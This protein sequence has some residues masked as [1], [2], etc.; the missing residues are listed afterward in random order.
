MKIENLVVFVT[1]FTININ[2]NNNKLLLYT[3]QTNFYK[4]LR[5]NNSKKIHS[6]TIEPAGYLI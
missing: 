4:L 1:F 5:G 3:R 2:N 6:E